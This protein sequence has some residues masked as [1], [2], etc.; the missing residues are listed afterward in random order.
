MPG[1]APYRVSG[2]VSPA[3]ERTRKQ[4]TDVRGIVDGGNREADDQI[5]DDHRQDSCSNGSLEIGWDRV[6][7]TKSEHQKHSEKAEIAPD[8]PAKMEYG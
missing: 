6:P 1:L 2:T 5:D 7:V 4:T 3:Q 8:A